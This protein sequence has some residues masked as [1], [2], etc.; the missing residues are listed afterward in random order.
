LEDAEDVLRMLRQNRIAA[1]YLLGDVDRA[2]R[3]RG[4]WYLAGDTLVSLQRLAQGA[5]LWAAGTANG[6]SAVLSSVRLPAELYFSG[7]ASLVEAL[8]HRYRVE[9]EEEMLRM[10]VTAGRFRPVGTATRLSPSD[11]D[12]INRLYRFGAGGQVSRH[13]VAAGVYYGIFD[14]GRLVAVAGTHFINATERLGAIGNVFTHPAYRGRGLATRTTSAVTMA[15]LDRCRDIVLNVSAGNL[16]AQA[17]YRKLGYRE[18]ARFVELYAVRRPR[19]PLGW[20]QRAAEA[21]RR[22]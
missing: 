19:G 2:G 18:V 15:I 3:P 4:E 14:E 21:L 7:P 8:H 6:L 1:A 22:P 20:L 17:V 16:P 11:T 9:F 10:A 13:Q 5:A 12:Q